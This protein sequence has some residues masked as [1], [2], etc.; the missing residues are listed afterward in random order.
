MTLPKRSKPIAWATSSSPSA[1]ASGMCRS[2]SSAGSSGSPA[3]ANRAPAAC[4]GGGRHGQAHEPGG[5]E[6][7]A[8]L[9]QRRPRGELRGDGGEQ[10]APVEGRRDRLQAVGRAAE[11]DRLDGAAEALGGERQQA[12]VGSD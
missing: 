11:V 1:W 8:R 3:P 12:V 10:V 7:T 4:G 6:R 5:T 9:R 2:T